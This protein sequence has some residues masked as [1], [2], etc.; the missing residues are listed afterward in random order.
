MDTRPINE[1]CSFVFLTC[2]ALSRDFSILNKIGEGDSANVFRVLEHASN[3][4]FA[5]KAFNH[6]N[7]RGTFHQS[8]LLSSTNTK[9]TGAFCKRCLPPSAIEWSK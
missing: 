7:L 4:H 8:N 6:K 1:D 3:N 9:S 5:L 2:R